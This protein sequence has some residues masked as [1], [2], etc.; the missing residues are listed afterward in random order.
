MLLPRSERHLFEASPHPDEQVCGVHTTFS[1]DLRGGTP[2]RC[3]RGPYHVI[4]TSYKPTLG[5]PITAQEI[6]PPIEQKFLPRV[7]MSDTD[8]TL[9][10]WFRLRFRIVQMGYVDGQ[11][12]WFLLERK[13]RIEDLMEG[14]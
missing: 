12:F 2:V 11:G 1:M 10:V 3:G 6:D 8:H 9:K 14:E 5:V 13:T 7:M 4:H